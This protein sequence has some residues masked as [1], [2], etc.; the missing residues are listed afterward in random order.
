VNGPSARRVAD[1]PA[2][3]V[4][5]SPPRH[6]ATTPSK[7]ERTQRRHARLPLRVLRS[8]LPLHTLRE[9]KLEARLTWLRLTRR[10]IDGRFAAASGVLVN[11]GCGPHGQ[12][13]WINIDCAPAKGVTCVRD[14]RTSLPLPTGSARGIFTEH[15]FE[16]LDYYEEA[17]RFLV[18]CRRVLEPGG[19]LRVI[20]PDGGKYL[21]AY[22]DDGWDSLRSFSS[23]TSWDPT[24]E[25][26]PFSTL[27]EVLPFRTKMEVIN[28]HFRQM[29][30]HR[31]SYDYETLAELLAQCGF[32]SV[33]VREY[34]MSALP[35]LAIDRDFRAA[36][37][38]VVEATA[39]AR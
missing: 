2:V 35:D 16:H 30:V 24:S 37:S 18:E 4:V 3:V 11:V 20:V 9:L 23:L 36:E 38:L 26:R 21:R 7:F 29:G 19:T 13:G 31:F 28:Y 15:F 33:T 25:E 32:E 17:P 10:G 27:R 5:D 22:V 8:L 39:P 12:E 34:R 6:N 14:C 1:H